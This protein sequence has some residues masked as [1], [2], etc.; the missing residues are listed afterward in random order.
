[1]TGAVDIP[2]TVTHE[3]P[4]TKGW[5]VTLDRYRYW[6]IA[7]VILILIAYAPFLISYLPGNFTSPGYQLY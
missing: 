5:A 4:A 7:T 3:G 2:F 1:M 6:V